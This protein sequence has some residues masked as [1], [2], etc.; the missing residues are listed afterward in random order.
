MIPVHD[1]GPVSRA[2]AALALAG[3]A[4]ASGAADAHRVAEAQE[5]PRDRYLQFVPLDPPRIV[6]GTPASARF[7]LYGDRSRPGYR[8]RRPRDGIDDGRHERLMELAVRFSPYLVRNTGSAPLHVREAMQPPEAFPLH[9]DRWDAVGPRPRI[10]ETRTVE[11]GAGPASTDDEALAELVRR[12]HPERPDLPAFGDAVTPAESH[13]VE[14]LYFDFPGTRPAEWKEEYY[15]STS[16]GVARA[17]ADARGIYCH[18]FVRRVSGEDDAYELVLQY[19]FFYPFNDGGNNHE[20]DWEHMNVIPAVAGQETTRLDPERVRALLGAPAAEPVPL[21]SLRLGRVEYYF[22]GKMMELDFLDP[23]VRLP[24]QEWERRLEEQGTDK[25]GERWMKRRVREMAYA[26]AD[27]TRANT[28]PVGYIGADNKGLDQLLSK[29]GGKN[30]D[31]HGTYPFPGLY[32]AVGLAGAT[33]EIDAPTNP[34]HGLSRDP[35]AGPGRLERFDRPD[36]IEIVPD[37]ERV[38]D[39]VAEDPDVRRRWAWLLLPIRWGYPAVQSRFAGVVSHA[40]TGNLAPLGPAYN[41]GWN[42]TGATLGYDRYDPHRFGGTLPLGWQDGFVNSWGFLNL[43]LPTLAVVP[44]FDFAWRVLAMPARAPIQSQKPT[45][46]PGESPPFRLVGAGGSVSVTRPPDELTLLFTDSG[47]FD[48]IRASVGDDDLG[49]EV[50]ERRTDVAVAPM[51]RFEFHVGERLV[52]ENTVRHLRAGVGID[53]RPAEETG[54]VP[55]RADLELWEYIG[56]LRYNLS[57]GLLQPFLRAGYGLSWYRLTDAAVAGEPLEP[58]GT[59][60]VRKP[61][62]IPPEDLLPN[63]WH[64]GLGIEVVPVRSFAPFPTG[65]DVGA[66][67]GWTIHAHGL[68]LGR[69]EFLSEQEDVT[70]GRNYLELGIS[71]TY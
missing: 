52:T 40:E 30:R 54:V 57:T 9:V 3:L 37:W 28:H 26:D 19:W 71:L 43:T 14:V 32:K 61:S 10:V 15:G 59:G 12:H 18:P 69:D 1:P 58:D 29:P 25:V 65:V 38:A 36:R 17:Y 45:F 39:L 22:H 66:R 56:S 2:L 31:S 53:V 21:D 64:A 67:L 49:A 16:D 35:G 6:S 11:M 27:E 55:V 48:Q 24:R 60:W 47:L 50:V 34:H 13:P 62:I 4:V 42:R 8:D 5:V 33:E 23:D 68:G 44:P 46:F 7:D 63:T 41:T 51:A 70:I 20:G